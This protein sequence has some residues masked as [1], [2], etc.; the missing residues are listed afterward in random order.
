[1]RPSPQLERALRRLHEAGSTAAVWD[2][3]L[4]VALVSVLW[5]MSLYPDAAPAA[6]ITGFAAVAASVARRSAPASLAAAVPGTVVAF[7]TVSSEVFSLWPAAAA[8]LVMVLSDATRRPRT[9][10]VRRVAAGVLGVV[11]AAWLLLDQPSSHGPQVL[12]AV[13]AVLL[14][15]GAR[16][17][18]RLLDAWIERQDQVA[19][20]QVRAAE[21]IES[22]LE[23]QRRQDLAR[24]LHDS[25]GHHL[26]AMVVQAEA[27]QVT[28][29]SPAL[30][31]IGDL[32]RDAL[33]ELEEVLFDLRNPDLV[34]LTRIDTHLAAPLRA[35]G[36]EVEVSLSSTARGP[37]R[38]AVYRIVQEALTNVM[39]HA[40]ATRVEVVVR[41]E[42]TGMIG[43]LVRDDGVG[44]ARSASGAGSGVQG[45]RA[46]AAE[47]GGSLT[48]GGARPS[49][50]L[51]EA[52]LKNGES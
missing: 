25:I 7:A 16:R 9:S 42:P 1:M 49:G 15:A 41:D 40:R 51:V 10:P 52:H 24:E 46:R 28:S 11:G 43:V 31:V 5:T 50:T 17:L 3:V 12:S 33:E 8:L 22:N 35:A 19:A 39:K 26:T 18:D 4:V 13:A 37:A 20:L 48:V 45:M 23:L 14:V 30:A 29:P 34:D 44:P 32:G 6:G 36:V 27:G 21:A 2:V 38:D 47:R